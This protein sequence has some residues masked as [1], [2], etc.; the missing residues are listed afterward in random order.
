[1]EDRQRRQDSGWS[2]DK[3]G[4]IK[5]IGTG[6]TW[7]EFLNISKDPAA[8]IA[9]MFTRAIL[10]EKSIGWLFVSTSLA[11]YVDENGKQTIDE[12]H[13]IDCANLCGAT[14]GRNGMGRNQ[15]LMGYTQIVAPAVLTGQDGARRKE[16]S[17]LD[18]EAS[19]QHNRDDED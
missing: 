5:P 11:T 13:L 19:R 18:R 10:P 1:M 6:S 12:E 15:A 16:P 8:K 2:K 14:V 17:K 4:N 7:K 9:N 3:L